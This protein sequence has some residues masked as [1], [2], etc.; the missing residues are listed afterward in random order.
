MQHPDVQPIRGDTAPALPWR[1]YPPPVPSRPGH[2][3]LTENLRRL[4]E[5]KGIPLTLVAG[6]AGVDSAELFAAMAGQI[7]PDLDWLNRIA[8][9]LGVEVAELVVDNQRDKPPPH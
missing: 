5:E 3:L 4:T 2:I 7:D 6:R 1:L 9:A 8:D